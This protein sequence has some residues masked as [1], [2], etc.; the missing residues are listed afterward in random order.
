MTNRMLDCT[1]S[2]CD[3]EKVE[4]IVAYPSTGCSFMKAGWRNILTAENPLKRPCLRANEAGNWMSFRH[5][6]HKLGLLLV[7]KKI[8][9]ALPYCRIG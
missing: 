9:R 6:A 5:R 4:A 3:L 1:L 7:A 8:V 2:P